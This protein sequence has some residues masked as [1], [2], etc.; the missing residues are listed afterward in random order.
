MSG[1]AALS[2]EEWSE[3]GFHANSRAQSMEPALSIYAM[4]CPAANQRLLD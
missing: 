2:P 4:S 1:G 3:D